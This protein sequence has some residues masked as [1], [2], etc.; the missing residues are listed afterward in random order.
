MADVEHART[1]SSERVD[2][3]ELDNVPLASRARA[4]L[5]TAILEDRFGGRLPSEDKLAEMLNVSRTT[6]RA[7]VQ[8]LERD[9]L[10]SRRRAV[11]TT[12]N[13]HVGPQTLA[14]QRLVG[15][16]WLL[17]EKG[18]SVKVDI[19]WEH[20]VPEKAVRSALPWSGTTECLIIEKRYFADDSLAIYLKDFIP[21]ENL[22]TDAFEAPLEASVFDFSQRYCRQRIAHAV[23]QIVPKVKRKDLNTE[24]TCRVGTPFIRLHET[25]HAANADVVGWSYI[26]IEDRFIRLEVFRGH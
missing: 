13:R 18:H 1:R 3:D 5:L 6:V 20:G 26:D 10:I 12:I 17:E 24:L 14:L 4:A 25:H 2:L 9:G 22:K 11:G 16:H 19:S 8:S 23:V 15:W 7:A 21:L